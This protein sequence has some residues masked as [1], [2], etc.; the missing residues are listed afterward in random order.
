MF[1]F[2]GLFRDWRCVRL[3]VAAFSGHHL[4]YANVPC[5]DPHAVATARVSRSAFRAI[6]PVI[7]DY[8]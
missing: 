7:M 3:L 4:L 5:D 1:A 2:L 8:G 6:R